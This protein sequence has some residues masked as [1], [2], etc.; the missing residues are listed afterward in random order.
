[1]IGSMSGT[2]LA[3]AAGSLLDPLSPLYAGLVGAG[4]ALATVL[5]D[6]GVA[7][8]EAGRVKAGEKTSRSPLRVAL[9]PLVGLAVA[10]PAA[11]VLGLL[12]LL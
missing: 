11:Y 12:L 3:A 9:G 7:Y 8:G 1:V 2:A 5:A 6:L 10:T 4:V